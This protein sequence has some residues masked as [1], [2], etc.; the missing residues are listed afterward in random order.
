VIELC[1]GWPEVDRAAMGVAGVCAGAL[2]A[3]L[4]RALDPRVAA[5]VL[6]PGSLAPAL[7]P[8]AALAAGRSRCRVLAAGTAGDRAIAWSERLGDGTPTLLDGDPLAAAA[9]R[10]AGEL[11]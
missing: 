7:D 4:L 6:A 8:D 2:G 5:S 11:A 1:A 10:L 9:Q 3:S